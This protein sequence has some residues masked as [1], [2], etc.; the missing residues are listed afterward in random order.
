L[1][2]KKKPSDLALGP[3]FTEHGSAG[4]VINAV[5]FLA[6]VSVAKATPA[7]GL[8]AHFQ[9]ITFN[10]VALCRRGAAS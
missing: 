8:E 3:K 5:S 7:D 2:A 9:F 1:P 6:P 4:T 10:F